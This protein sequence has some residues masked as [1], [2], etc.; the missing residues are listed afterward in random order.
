MIKVHGAS[1]NS[2][3]K[4]AW[5][6]IATLMDGIRSLVSDM[7][8][9]EYQHKPKVIVFFFEIRTISIAMPAKKN[10]DESVE[11]FCA[12]TRIPIGTYMKD[13]RLET[14][15]KNWFHCYGNSILSAPCGIPSMWG[16][17][18]DQL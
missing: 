9:F 14:S 15:E 2:F 12:S 6:F 1:N 3:S 7:F 10:M 17:Q 13:L 5:F 16:S 4:H 11:N 18:T 8:V